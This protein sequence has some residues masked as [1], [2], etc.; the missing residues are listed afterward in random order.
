MRFRSAVLSLL[1]VLTST[2]ACA[3]GQAGNEATL[4]VQQVIVVKSTAFAD[5]EP[6]A[7][8]FTCDGAGEVRSDGKGFGPRH[9][10]PHAWRRALC[11]VREEEVVLQPADQTLW[12]G[13]PT[14]G[15]QRMAQGQLAAI[16][17]GGGEQGPGQVTHL[18]LAQLRQQV[19]QRRIHRPSIAEPVCCG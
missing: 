2:A 5:G 4:S 13:E 14:T 12:L 11:I 18:G 1:A 15:C 6:L 16:E 19:I 17:Q 9:C 8:R 7:S 3:A 10:P